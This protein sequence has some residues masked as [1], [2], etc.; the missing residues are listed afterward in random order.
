ML[1]GSYTKF[2]HSVNGGFLGLAIGDA[3]GVPVE[4]LSHEAI[5]A[6]TDGA[7]VT[8]Y[9]IPQQMRIKDTVNL[10]PGS[11]SDDTQ[12]TLVT[13]RS[14]VRCKGFNLID[15]GLGLVEEYE[16]SK[17][18][19]GRT[20]TEAAQAIKLWRDSNH[21][22]GRHPAIPVPR[23]D[24][25]GASAGSGPAMKIF[26]LAVHDLFGRDTFNAEMAFH[27]HAV[28]LGRMTHGDLRAVIASVALGY[29]IACFANAPE[30]LAP[31]FRAKT[32]TRIL[33]MVHRAE[34]SYKYCKPRTPPFSEYLAR[35]F[36]LL[37]DPV[38]LRTEVNASFRA[39]HSVPFAIATA[40]RHPND[41]RAGVLEAVNAG[42]D[43]DTI[44]SMVGAIL[45][46]RCGTE[47]MPPEWIIGL[48]GIVLVLDE[49]DALSR[50][51]FGVDANVP[52]L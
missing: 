23:P 30:V 48:R 6:A 10:P 24:K 25:D 40:L 17:F 27:T 20:T 19:W 22:F 2:C 37:D 35:A 12:L 49:A 21:K 44:G 32:T 14:L 26:P 52:T 46:S 15:Q 5:L 34:Y 39:V 36:A 1:T 11:T 31:D 28:D 38:A 51:L 8:G 16:R 42:R 18:G 47:R 50:M 13:S 3:L 29:A 43:T 45:G 33:E 41:F 4:T 9:I 7:G